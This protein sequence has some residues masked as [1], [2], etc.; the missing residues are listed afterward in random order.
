MTFPGKIL[1]ILINVFNWFYFIQ[2][3]FSI[4]L[5]SL[6]SL[7]L[8]VSSSTDSKSKPRATAFVVENVN[9]HHKDWFNYFDGTDMLGEL[10]YIF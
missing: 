3:P 5:Y 9:I 7:V 1:K 4:N 2:C 6:L 10:C 8:S